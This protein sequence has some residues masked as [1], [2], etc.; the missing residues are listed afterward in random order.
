MAF[1]TSWRTL[2][3]SVCELSSG[4]VLFSDFSPVQHLSCT[5]FDCMNIVINGLWSHEVLTQLIHSALPRYSW[6][7]ILTCEQL[8]TNTHLLCKTK[9]KI[10]VCSMKYREMDN[11]FI[12]TPPTP[13]QQLMIP[14]NQWVLIWWFTLT[15]KSKFSHAYVLPNC[16]KCLSPFSFIETRKFWISKNNQSKQRG[17]AFKHFWSILFFKA[18]GKAVNRDLIW[19]KRI[20]KYT[21]HFLISAKDSQEYTFHRII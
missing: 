17:H 7:S 8:E 16:A 11:Y 15:Y 18:R 6:I 9:G 1:K 19:A 21:G 4:L 12:P 3:Y 10:L 14:P 20:F 5:F 2:F 13:K